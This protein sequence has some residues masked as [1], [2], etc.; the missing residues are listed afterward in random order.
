MNKLTALETFKVDVVVQ[1]T[2][3]KLS[4]LDT[5]KSNA[6]QEMS[7]MMSEEISRVMT[8][9]RN[10]EKKYARLGQ[11]RAQLK[12]LKNKENLKDTLEEIKDTAKELKESTRA[13]C[14]VLKDN[15]DISGNQAKIRDD[16]YE[17]QN[18]SSDLLLEIKDLSFAKFKTTIKDGLENME[19]L[20]KLRKEE[21]DLQT[22]IK[23]INTERNEKQKESTAEFEET[24]SDIKMLEKSLN[25]AKTDSELFLRYL[26]NEAQGKQDCQLRL[27]EQT[28]REL[29]DKIKDLEDRIERENLVSNKIKDFLRLKKEKLEK[30][31]ESWD[32]KK[33]K[34]IERLTKFINDISNNKSEDESKQE[35]VDSQLQFEMAELESQKKM[36]I[37]KEKSLQRK[38]EE[39]IARDN[40]ARYLQQKWIWWKTVG[41]TFSKKGRKKG[42]KKK[43]KK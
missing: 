43:K 10:L 38:K 41:K 31:S 40:A 17:L 2:I 36:E 24:Q 23:Q 13:L 3:D 6:G 19:K 37:E 16:R 28:E 35:E 33:D 5:L 4:F 25:D 42:G 1:E 18:C 11:Q 14:R 34:E 30:E 22:K 26:Q 27:F 12:G 20:D 15:P 7:E 32:D 39:N 21:K 29:E 8:E 9:Q